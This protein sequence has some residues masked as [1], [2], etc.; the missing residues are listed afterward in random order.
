MGSYTSKINFNFSKFIKELTTKKKWTTPDGN[1]IGY[2]DINLALEKACGGRKNFQECD[3]LMR[4]VKSNSILLLTNEYMEDAKKQFKRIDNSLVYTP[5]MQIIELGGEHMDEVFSEYAYLSSSKTDKSF[6]MNLDDYHSNYDFETIRI[7]NKIKKSELKNISNT[8]LKHY[9][10]T[11][12]NCNRVIFNSDFNWKIQNLKKKFIKSAK[13]REKIQT[14][15]I[16]DGESDDRTDD[17]KKV[18]LYLI[19]GRKISRW[20]DFKNFKLTKGKNYEFI[21]IKK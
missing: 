6:L 15:Y 5:V 14:D 8:I 7:F 2:E 16:M 1:K 12:T 21:N 10:F 3:E 9:D 13:L 4:E 18:H 11:N 17:E 19:N 20:Y